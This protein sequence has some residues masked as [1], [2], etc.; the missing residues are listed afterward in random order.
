VKNLEA[1][2]GGY[3]SSP[4]LGNLWRGGTLLARF[5]H[6]R[7]ERVNLRLGSLGGGQAVFRGCTFSAM[8]EDP[9]RSTSSGLRFDGCVTEPLIDRESYRCARKPL[10]ELSAW[11]E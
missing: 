5:D 9:M 1:I 2:S 3:E 10:S 8:L 4:G 11:F 6:C 7:F